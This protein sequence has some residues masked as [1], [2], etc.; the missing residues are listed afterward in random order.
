MI[1]NH[2]LHY[3]G[4]A[5]TAACEVK[6]AFEKSRAN[7]RSPMINISLLL[8]VALKQWSKCQNKNL[9]TCANTV[10]TKSVLQKGLETF[11]NC[12]SRTG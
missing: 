8:T 10:T 6:Q 12:C 2:E 3:Y 11:K 7:I 4:N 5:K 1:N 9:K